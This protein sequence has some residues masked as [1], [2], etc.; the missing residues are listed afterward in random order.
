MQQQSKEVVFTYETL[1]ELL[2]REK[3]KQELQ[4]VEPTFLSDALSYLREKQQSYDDTIAKDDIFSKGEREKLTTQ[5]KNAKKILRDLYDLRERKI[6]N[7]AINHSRIGARIADMENLLTH[8]K[9]L[10]ENVSA[11][12]KHQRSAVLSKL[13]ELREP[14]DIIPS[15]NHAPE[16]KE[17]PDFAD[18]TFLD[19][20]EEFLGEE[21]EVY[22]P[23]KA[24]ERAKVP[25]KVADILIK[26]GKAI[27]N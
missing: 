13:L 2:R 8:E 15:H 26:Q 11:T 16:R 25:Q 10:F 7:M 21:L 19:D 1:Y 14:D 22:G 17:K 12:L 23:Y 6:I 5:I 9:E 4:K 27:Q 3:A 24:Q 18:I 20:V